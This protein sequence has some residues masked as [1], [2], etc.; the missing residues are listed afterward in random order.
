MDNMICWDCVLKHLAGALSYG[1]E[2]LSGHTRG[3]GL[4]HRVDFL[5]ELVNAEH[6]LELMDRGVL[7]IVSNFRKEMQAKKGMVGIEDLATVRRM[8]LKAEELSGATNETQLR[9]TGNAFRSDFGALNYENRTGGK[10]TAL[11]PE[12]TG[13]LDVVYNFVDDYEQF[14]YSYESIRK[15]AL[16]H[17]KIYVLKSEIDLTDF[18]VETIGKSLSEFCADERLT[19]DFLLTGQNMA[20]LREFDVRKSFPVF[21]YK[22]IKEMHETMKFLKEKGYQGHIYLWDGIKQQPVN[23]SKYL[24]LMKEVETDHPLTAYYSLK[25]EEKSFNAQNIVCHIDR[26]VCCSTK[27]MLKNSCFVTW[28]NADCFRYLTDFIK[29]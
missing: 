19:E 16:N 28:Q 3:A 8:Y 4:D 12:Y 23:K 7:N 24:E 15:Y 10:I 6:H 21:S 26:P 20:L 17:G 18:E 5:G 9:E 25:N 29:K 27:S 14:K 22:V 2:V 13:N 1:K 11:Y